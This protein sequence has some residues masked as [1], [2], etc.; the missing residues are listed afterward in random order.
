ME[1]LAV[2]PLTLRLIEGHDVFLDVANDLLDPKVES[3]GQDN[4]EPNGSHT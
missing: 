2:R 1:G 3:S 4:R